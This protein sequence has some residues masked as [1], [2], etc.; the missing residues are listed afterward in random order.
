MYLSRRSLPVY[1]TDQA[2]VVVHEDVVFIEV[3]VVNHKGLAL[4]WEDLWDK[5]Q[6]SLCSALID[7]GIILIRVVFII[8]FVVE[9]EDL[10]L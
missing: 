1:D 2:T 9:V 4:A 10:K 8:L 7:L 6:E 3:V 5:I